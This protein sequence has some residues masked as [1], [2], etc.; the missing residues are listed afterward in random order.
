MTVTV[1]EA[2][3]LL[4]NYKGWSYLEFLSATDFVKD[5]MTLCNLPVYIKDMYKIIVYAVI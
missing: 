1:M 4:H 3:L 2:T 5:E